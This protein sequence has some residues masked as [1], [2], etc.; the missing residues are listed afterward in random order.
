MDRVRIF[1]IHDLRTDEFPNYT[2]CGI[3][4]EPFPQSMRTSE[5]RSCRACR[6]NP[7]S[8]TVIRR[9]QN[10]VRRATNV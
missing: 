7:L 2:A 8:A 4:I 3:L 6:D 5:E 10:R 9:R 1:A